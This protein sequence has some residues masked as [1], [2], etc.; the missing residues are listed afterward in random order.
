MV[1]LQP[2][3]VTNN[4]LTSLGSWCTW[5]RRLTIFVPK[6]HH[7]TSKDPTDWYQQV[8]T[9]PIHPHW[10]TSL[11]TC[12]C[13]WWWWCLALKCFF[14]IIIVATGSSQGETVGWMEICFLATDMS[15]EKYGWICWSFQPGVVKLN[16][17]RIEEGEKQTT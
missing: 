12:C 9:F 11:P 10:P 7:A 3:L 13:W 14:Q 2:G 6:V 15:G 16:I 8:V 4:S 17:Y 1:I 5:L